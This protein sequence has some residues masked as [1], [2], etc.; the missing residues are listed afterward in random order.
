MRTLGN[1]MAWIIKSLKAGDPPPK[2]EE[3][4]MMTSFHDGK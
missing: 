4:R 1:N 2:Q 3:K